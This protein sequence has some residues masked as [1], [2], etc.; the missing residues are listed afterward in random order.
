M[1]YCTETK[2]IETHVLH[3]FNPL[4]QA[5]PFPSLL[6]CTFMLFLGN[7]KAQNRSIPFSFHLDHAATTSAGVFK[8]DSTLLRTLWSNVRYGA[9]THT[10]SWDRKDDAGHLVA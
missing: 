2:N 8:K 7:I 3:L 6:L 9:G 1:P 5:K 10:A 4:R